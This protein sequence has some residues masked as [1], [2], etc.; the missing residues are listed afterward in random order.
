MISSDYS[1]SGPQKYQPRNYRTR[2][3]RPGFVPFRVQIK[4][5]DLFILAQKDYSETALK[6]VYKYR[7]Y[8][9]EYINSRPEFEESLFPI[10]EDPHATPIVRE[11]ISAA[12]TAGVGPMSSV[13]G[14]VAQYVSLDLLEFTPEVIVENGGD[15]Y[16]KSDQDLRVSVYAGNSP[17]NMKLNLRV[18]SEDTPLGICTSSGTIGHSLSFGRADAVCIISKSAVLADAAATAVGN[19]VKGAEDIRSALQFGKSIPGVLGI[20]IIIG[21]KMG[22]VGKIELD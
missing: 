10:S 15:I 14:A 8:L 22:A 13:A 20:L 12:T 11:M 4:E 1:S 19:R 2:V 18:R 6:S 16:V 5:T 21:T 7:T 3:G 17:L 9:E